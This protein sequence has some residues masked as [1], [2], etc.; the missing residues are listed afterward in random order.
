MLAREV[1]QKLLPRIRARSRRFRHRRN[2]HLFRGDRRRL[3]RLHAAGRRERPPALSVVVVGDVSGHGVVAALT[4]M[5]VRA[6]LQEAYAGDGTSL[7]PG[8]ARGQSP[9]HGRH[10]RRPVRDID[11]YGDLTFES[12]HVRWTQ[13]RSRADLLFYDTHGKRFE[14][15]ARC[16][17]FPWAS[18]KPIGRSTKMT[19]NFGRRSASS[20][21][22]PTA[23]GRHRTRTVRN[24]ARTP[25]W[26]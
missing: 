21:L 6:L 5:A 15:L 17:T 23:F 20:L 4:M 18:A 12:R 1:Q 16:T 7:R 14:E 8:H 3:L 2:Q 22:V 24:S 26:T 11:L 9:P 19:A 10:C 25:S 13:R